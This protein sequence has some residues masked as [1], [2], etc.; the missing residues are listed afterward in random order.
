MLRRK[1]VNSLCASVLARAFAFVLAFP[2]VFASAFTCTAAS[3]AEKSAPSVKTVRFA[4]LI[5]ETEFDPVRVSDLYSYT[6]IDAIFEPLLKYD[7]LARPVKLKPNVAAAMPEVTEEGK[8]YTFKIRPGILFSDDAAFGGK[9]RELTAQDFAY[10]IRRMYDP[11]NRSPNLWYVEGKIVGGDESMEAAK[12]SGRYNYDSPIAGIETPDKYTLRIRIKE[13]DYNFLYVFAAGQTA[14]IAREVVE[15]YGE[16][17]GAH[18]VG[19]GPFR[20]TEWK[21]SHKIVLEANPNF[22][23]EFFDAEPTN[24]PRSQAIAK[25]MKGRKLPRVQR[26]EVSVIEESQPRWLAFING[27]T[28]YANAPND[29]AGYAFPGGKIAPFL[30]K[31]GIEGERFVETDLA[32]TFFNFDH[33]VVG[34]ITPEKIALRRAIVLG[35]NLQEEI[36]II[37]NG[38]AIKAESPIP[39][40]VEGYDENFRLQD[41]T[42]SPSR[43]MALLDL[44][45][46]RDRDGDGFREDPNGKQLTIEIANEP[47]ANTTKYVTL[48][49]KNMA[50]IGLRTRFRRE[51]FPDLNKAAKAGHLAMWPQAWSA[52]YPDA[53]NFF[54]NLY[55][56]NAVDG[57]G[58]FARFRNA[59][60][61][62]LY[63]KSRRM[64]PSPERNKIYLEMRRII[65]VYVP[66]LPQVHR[67]RSEAWQPWLIGYTK[68]PIYN[69]VWKYID[70]DDSKRP[71]Q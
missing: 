47:D 57:G 66:W 33:P 53:E 63:E 69:Q 32:Y 10:A 5:A 26:V 39:P 19:T 43:A 71:K 18:P 42:Y 25:Q 22:R 67:L 2:F 3:A 68:H 24:E 11:K 30:A 46:Y 50:A 54:Q 8:L 58:N 49:Q 15:R 62:A 65:A 7:Y 28:D 27:E 60:F 48:W 41:N 21:R 59:Q 34:G 36:D 31:V 20:L 17:V 29:F 52:D 38:G 23:E 70:I 6:I 14:A 13:A 51:K 37:R 55:G 61:D 16:N 12:K 45:G 40:G 56:A 64:P 44:Y 1:I 9:K 4:F 35:Y